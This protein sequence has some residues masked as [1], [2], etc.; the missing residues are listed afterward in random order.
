[1]LGSGR[2]TSRA[3]AVTILGVSDDLDRARFLQGLGRGLRRPWRLNEATRLSLDSLARRYAAKRGLGHQAAGK[4]PPATW[5]LETVLPAK[6]HSFLRGALGGG[7]EGVLFYAEREIPVKRGAVMEGWT[8]ALYE[9][10]QAA[11][12]AYG[13]ACLFRPGAGTG[14]RRP[15]AVEAPRG[16]NEVALGATLDERFLVA[17]A[18]DDRDPLARLFTAEF[19]AWLDGLPWRA[20]GA[21]VPRFELRNGR[22]CVYAKPKARTATAL[23]AFAG[24][25]ALIAAQVIEAAGDV[26]ARPQ[27]PS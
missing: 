14:G 8:V 12:L 13:I 3:H 2:S 19:I 11:G 10:P 15:L 23:D 1:M 4:T 7:V 20:T 5:F 6:S 22:L 26:R 17:V 18:D 21:E 24:R 16:L 25:A 27:S 9:L